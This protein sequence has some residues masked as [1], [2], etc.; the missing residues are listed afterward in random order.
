MKF[1]EVAIPKLLDLLDDQPFAPNA[2]TLAWSPCVR[3]INLEI[4]EGSHHF[5]IGQ[6]LKTIE[7]LEQTVS[8]FDA[9]I[10]A[11]LAPFRD[12]IERLKEVPGLS[13]TSAQI[14]LAEIGTDMSQFP[15]AGHLLSWAG[16]VP[17]LDESAG[18]RRSIR[19]K[20]GA[21]GLKPI[22]VQCVWAASRNKNSYFPE[23]RR[24][25]HGNR[26]LFGST[27]A[28]G[29][30]GTGPLLPPRSSPRPIT[31]WP[32][33]PATTTSATIASLVA[34]PPASVAA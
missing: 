12:T 31:C 7:Q 5:L 34:T 13:E 1:A 9:R 32:T 28:L 26:G 4:F 14:L 10:E 2:I 25:Y 21:P 19:V 27:A 20:K 11:A 24:P 22:L 3:H 33:A 30:A 6:H 18:R 17:R 29:G 8:D 15:T 16:L 23:T